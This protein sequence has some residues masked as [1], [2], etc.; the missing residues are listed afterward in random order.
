MVATPAPVTSS[1]SSS[2]TTDLADGKVHPVCIVGSGIGGLGVAL[3]VY[4]L[5]SQ[6]ALVLE[7]EGIIGGKIRTSYKGSQKSER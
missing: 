1:P 7:K 2:P 4:R 5:T 6:P 3:E